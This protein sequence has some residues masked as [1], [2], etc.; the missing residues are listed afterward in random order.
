MKLAY[1]LHVN[2]L[3][4]KCRKSDTYKTKIYKDGKLYILDL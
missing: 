3:F 1:Q 4:I 2:V